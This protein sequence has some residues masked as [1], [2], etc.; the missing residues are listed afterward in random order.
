MGNQYRREN[1]V[2]QA[3]C[4]VVLSCLFLTFVFVPLE[5][6]IVP[7]HD[8]YFIPFAQTDKVW[9]PIISVIHCH[10]QSCS[11]PDGSWRWEMQKRRS[12]KITDSSCACGQHY[13]K[14][15]YINGDSSSSLA[16][17][18]WGSKSK[19]PW[20]N[21]SLSVC[22]FWKLVKNTW[23]SLHHCT[24]MEIN[25]KKHVGKKTPCSSPERSSH[26]TKQ[27]VSQSSSSGG[28]ITH[29]DFCLLFFLKTSI[30]LLHINTHRKIRSAVNNLNNRS[31]PNPNKN[32][33]VSA[34][35]SLW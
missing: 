25:N 3:G 32:H 17:A 4:G 7:G 18:V 30:C 26:S 2:A 33:D 11:V 20:W 29:F 13:Q 21:A 5:N 23:H 19:C 28:N 15:F 27:N 6:A 22:A 1:H 12:F 10:P 14:Y 16:T 8:H 31:I 34:A 24:T 9:G 35:A